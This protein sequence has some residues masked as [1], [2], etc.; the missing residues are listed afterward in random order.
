MKVYRPTDNKITRGYSST[1]RGYDFAGLNLPDEVRAGMDGEIIERVDLYTSNWTNTG[2]LTTRDYGNYIKIKH[3][4]GSYE[5]HAHLRK[6][7][8][9]YVGTKVKAGQT[10]ARIGNT[11]NSTGP[12]LH[13]EYRTSG[14]VNTTAE[15]YTGTSADPLQECLRQHA[16]LVKETT[17]LKKKIEDLIATEQRLIKEKDGAVRAKDEEIVKLRNEI[18]SLKGE[19]T[20][21]NITIERLQHENKQLL[22]QVQEGRQKIIDEYRQKLISNFTS[23]IN[24]IK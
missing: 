7:S 9:Y 21:L 3:N 18:E 19:R 6:G 24:S 2:T 14:N 13:S 12:H 1:H 8:S 17:E 5:L 22:S 23:W 10:V 15:F 4:D 16:D 20:A 11:G